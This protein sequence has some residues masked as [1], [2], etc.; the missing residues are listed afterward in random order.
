[1]K[2]IIY[3]K[4]CFD[5]FL[6][7][8]S[9]WMALK[10]QKVEATYIGANYNEPFVV[11]DEKLTGAEIYIVDFSYPKEELLRVKNIAKSLTIL[12]HHMTAKA[13]LAGLDFAHFDLDQSGAMLAWKHFHPG[14]K[15]PK[16]I[17]YVQDRD[18]WLWKQPESK[19][20]NAVIQSHNIGEEL[21]FPSFCELR[22]RLED[23]QQFLGLIKEGEAILRSQDQYM[24]IAVKRTAK[25]IKLAG[26][27]IPVVNSSVFESELCHKLIALYPGV[28]FGAVYYDFGTDGFQ[29]WSLR[30]EGDFDVSA[31]AAKFN[32]G[33]HKNAAGFRKKR[34]QE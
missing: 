19:K 27:D 11:A 15:A 9:V 28:P 4:N 26:Y 8:W 13:Q 32:G 22:D 1:M 10:D 14:T 12:D 34:D 7:A 17:E 2:Y 31:V 16:M 6:A 23:E 24:N 3:H 33:G 25:M 20:I 29:A 30:S 21:N 5:G 18:L